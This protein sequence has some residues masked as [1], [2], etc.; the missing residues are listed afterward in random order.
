MKITQFVIHNWYLF[1]ALVVV[2][3]LMLKE[4]VLRL[5]HRVSNVSATEAV[6]LINR[7]DGVVVD[8][9]DTKEFGSGHIGNAINIPLAEFDARVR[10]LEK[11]KH[12]PVILSGGANDAAAKA[13]VRLRRHGFENLAVLAG[14]MAAWERSQ[15]P[16][17]K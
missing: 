14:G 10:E 1:V 3:A 15:L 11:Y 5:M 16:V 12:K 9:R 13:A 17:A 8:V 6:L 7:Q 4:P 2:I